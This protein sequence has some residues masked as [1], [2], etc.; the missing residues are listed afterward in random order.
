[1]TAGAA[2]AVYGL[3]PNHTAICHQTDV[4]DRILAAFFC[5]KRSCFDWYMNLCLPQRIE[6]IFVVR[7]VFER[8]LDPDIAEQMIES[9]ISEGEPGK[10]SVRFGVELVQANLDE[11]LP[12]LS[13][14]PLWKW[15]EEEDFIMFAAVVQKEWSRFS[16]VSRRSAFSLKQ[17]L[18]YWRG[19]KKHLLEFN[20]DDV[21]TT[22]TITDDNEEEEDSVEIACE[23]SPNDGDVAVDVEVLACNSPDRAEPKWSKSIGKRNVEAALAARRLKL[24]QKKTVSEHMAVCRANKKVYQLSRQLDSTCEK[25]PVPLHVESVDKKTQPLIYRVLEFALGSCRNVPY[26]DDVRHFWLMINS[27]SPACCDYL[28]RLM[29]GPCRRT[30]TRW[31]SKE[32]ADLKAELFDLQA[33]GRIVDRWKKKWGDCTRS[34]FTLSYDACKLDEDLVIH[35][36]GRVTGTI[37]VVN[38]D[39]PAIEY[40]LDPSLYASLWEEQI[41]QKNLITHA[42]VFILTPVDERKG[43]PVHCV[44]AN[45]GSATQQ[46]L[47]C[48]RELPVILDRMG[49]HVVFSASDSDSKYR[50]FFSHQFKEI[51]KQFS[52]LYEINMATGHINGIGSIRIP[53]VKC[54]NDI[55]HINKRWRRRLVNN[56]S[57]S[58]SVEATGEM[59]LSPSVLMGINPQI[60]ASAFRRGSMPAMD[61]TYPRLMFTVETLLCAWTHEHWGAV[62]YLLPVVCSR[63]VFYHK[64]VS[65]VDRFRLAFLGWCLCNFYY[66]YLD[67]CGERLNNPILSRDLLVDMANALLCQMCALCQVNAAYRASKISSTACEH[68]FARVRRVMGQDQSVQSFVSGLLRCVV[69]DLEDNC[70]HEDLRIPRRSFDSARCEEGA[71][72]LSFESMLEVRDFI[73][74]LFFK[75]KVQLSPQAALHQTLAQANDYHLQNSSLI[76]LLFELNKAE[77][78]VHRF[79]VHAGQT[80]LRRIYGRQILA[81][82]KTAARKESLIEPEVRLHMAADPQEQCGEDEGD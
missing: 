25:Q 38:L 50:M 63:I 64:G 31:M 2:E 71:C 78:P 45:T 35:D 77:T 4:D 41:L 13:G 52:S 65:R 14:F 70:F 66:S 34:V 29:R 81:R 51:Y 82:Y 18:A 55:P 21:I 46:V 22:D 72:E 20:I 57:L 37:N 9:L 8:L 19:V 11:L 60:P 47:H 49:I 16:K 68:L 15:T 6:V 61:D 79:A 5:V 39:V 27:I 7:A 42:F 75:S 53:V 73:A 28:S 23:A 24:Q 48:I 26:P 10:L 62:L 32:K 69:A 36:D 30:V 80:R 1:M 67:D 33:V 56:V 58:W 40:K 54:C 44:L 17:R 43:F 3:W 12:Q 76:G 59:M 74:A